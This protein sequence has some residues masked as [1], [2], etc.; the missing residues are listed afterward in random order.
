MITKIIHQTAPNDKNKWHPIWETCQ[1]TWQKHFSFPE[2]KYKLWNDDDLYELIK[3]YFPQ[4]IKLY[5][6]FGND[7]IL[8]V[9]F[10]RYA[11]LYKYGGI[12]AD[13]D[14]MCKKNFY[15][16]LTNNL[17]IVESSASS[18]IVQNSLMASP[19][20]DNRWLKVMDNCKNYFYEFKK[21][22][23]NVSITGKNVIDISGPRLLSRA[24][25]MNSI[26]ILP[27]ILYNPNK[28]SFGNDNIFT[29]HY[30]T[31]KWGPSAGIRDFSKLLDEDIQKSYVKKNLEGCL[32]LECGSSRLRKKNIPIPIPLSKN[33]ITLCKN[34][35]KDTFK[36]SYDSNRSINMERT[37][38]RRGW[39]H[40]HSIYIDSDI[41][42]NFEIDDNPF[43]FNID[44]LKVYNINSPLTRIGKDGDGGYC[45]YLQDNY[46]I[47]ISGG[48]SGDISFEEQFL[49]KY[50]IPC[51]A[52][53]G[54][55]S[56]LPKNNNKI[57]F[58]KLYIGDI[59][60]DNNTNLHDLID[61]YN[62]I[63]LK[64][65]IEGGEFPFFHSLNSN[66]M[67]RLKQIVLEIHFPTTPHRWKILDKLAETHYLIHIH[68]NNFQKKI[69]I[70]DIEQS[71]LKIHVG[72]S[73]THTKTVKLSCKIPNYTV[74]TKHNDNNSSHEFNFVIN[75][76]ELTVGRIDKKTGWNYDLY[77]NVNTHY[78]NKTNSN[79]KIPLVFEC[80]YV[81]KSD[82][83]YKL[84][85]NT[86]EFPKEIDMANDGS[87][88]DVILNYY[89]FVNK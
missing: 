83:D 65:D 44:S 16:Q 82:I 30:G 63:F 57:S 59:N 27:K 52:F 18:E 50:N 88:Q 55:I 32:L 23:K 79:I 75:N 2:F 17:I 64:M 25:D 33:N 8:K 11:I 47:L 10:A 68:G 38:L 84:K 40:N 43:T 7:I 21:K 58:N 22:N 51:E 73:T 19:P 89:P 26:Q 60:N 4:Y 42:S 41:L 72:S 54:S 86:I 71:N 15:N 77:V 76:D 85:L 35:Y 74:L 14:F 37:D 29:K 39:G 87:R 1:K 67:N 78:I 13:M 45:V 48:I 81:R 66:Q 49:K 80:T 34:K 20:N 56:K 53:D 62:N 24:L 70:K 6:D 61:K 9:D 5:N 28:S 31:G 69:S 36:I 3:N 46:D 12:Y